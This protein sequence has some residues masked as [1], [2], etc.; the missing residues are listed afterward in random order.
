[1][2]KGSQSMKEIA[3]SVYAKSGNLSR[4]TFY[5]RL[6]Y[7]SYRDLLRTSDIHVY[8]SRPFIASWGLV[9]ALSC[10]CCV[11][12][13]DINMVREIVQESAFLID[14]TNVDESI[15]AVEFLLKSPDLRKKLSKNTSS[16]M[17]PTGLLM[18]VTTLTATVSWHIAPLSLSWLILGFRNPPRGSGNDILTSLETSPLTPSRVSAVSDHAIRI[19]AQATGISAGLHVL[20]SGTGLLVV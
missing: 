19:R 10:G 1:M 8:F 15:S 17:S 18:S 5:E 16:V 9:E 4:V 11:I 13:S 6:D 7:S 14:H 20:Y 3:L 12:A 2:P